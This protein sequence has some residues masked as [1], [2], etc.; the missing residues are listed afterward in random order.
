MPGMLPCV[1]TRSGAP[2]RRSLLA[3]LAALPLVRPALAQRGF[4]ER[5]IRLIVPFG[6]GTATD[7]LARQLSA[8]TLPFLGQPVVIENRA[9]ANAIIGTEAA[10]RSAPDGYTLLYGTTQ[11]LCY[12]PVMYQRLPYDPVRDFAPVAG[13]V[14]LSYLLVANAALPIRSVAD[15][16]AFAKAEPGRLT[17][18]STGAGT[19]SRL[20]AE[21]F[22][23][24]AGIE[25]TNVSY[26][27]GA[28]QLF[29]DLIAGR[30]A[31]MFYPYQFVRTHL[32]AGQL[33]ALASTDSRRTPWVPEVPTLAELGYRNSVYTTWFAIYAPAGTPEDRIARISDAYR[34]MLET[35]ALR[36]AL[37]ADGT[38]TDFRPPAA[39]AAFVAEERIRCRAVVELSGA[40]V[41]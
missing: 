4:P 2:G 27:T 14:S 12:N 8:G 22:A 39:L 35:P 5:P 41:Q 30:T 18:G 10:A 9:G 23:K 40:T 21:V 17:F 25:V 16:V 15:L 26:Q 37:A 31:M 34:Q 3:G 33:R 20:I 32:E 13:L 11:A 28:G 1:G 24:E 19:G 38:S 29:S 6:P 36:D 7:T